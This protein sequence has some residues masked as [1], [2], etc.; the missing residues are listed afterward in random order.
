MAQK[1]IF[2]YQRNPKPENVFSNSG[3]I[4]TFG[5]DA[6]QKGPGNLIQNWNVTYNNNITEI[7]EL[8][9][10][11]IYW[12]QGR[13]TGTANVARIIGLGNVKLLPE[14]AY[15]VCKGGA[16]LRI[17]AKPGACEGEK[18]NTLNLEMDGC[19]V[20]SIGFSAAV[21]DTR[22]NE[23]IAWRFSTLKLAE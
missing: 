12:V 3:A 18:L 22:I 11:N 13:P 1:D 14:S 15:D 17:T 5:G 10:P 20:T 19:I 8:G 2:G 16:L 7:F 21:A 6:S 23:T 4:M 9:S